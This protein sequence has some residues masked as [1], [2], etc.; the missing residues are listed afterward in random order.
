MLQV[1]AYEKAV[2]DSFKKAPKRNF[3]IGASQLPKQSAPTGH[4]RQP[5]VTP[6]DAAD[7]WLWTTGLS[8]SAWSSAADLLASAASF[9]V[10]QG[11]GM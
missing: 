5:M 6:I 1:H 10:A 8:L 4:G 11:R 2:V 7:D 3:A 9:D